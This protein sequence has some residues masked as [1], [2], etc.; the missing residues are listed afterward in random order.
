M[1]GVEF[2]EDLDTV[3][4]DQS[5]LLAVRAQLPV[6]DSQKF[7]KTYY[8]YK[9]LMENQDTDG[10]VTGYSINESTAKSTDDART[11]HAEKLKRRVE[12]KRWLLVNYDLRSML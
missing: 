10:S 2:V 1:I 8:H 11:K 3:F 9:D 5:L 6:T 4:E 12:G 7:E